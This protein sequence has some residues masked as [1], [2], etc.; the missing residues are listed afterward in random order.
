MTPTR[1]RL[2]ITA[3]LGLCLAGCQTSS[4]SGGMETVYADVHQG[5]LEQARIELERVLASQPEEASL[6]L[7]ERA[8]LHQRMR[9]FAASRDDFLRADEDFEVIDFSGEPGEDFAL[10]LARPKMAEYRGTPYEKILLNTLNIINHLALSDLEEGR[11]EARRAMVMHESVVDYERQCEF[12]NPLTEL[13]YGFLFE[14]SGRPDD[15]HF[16]Y[17]QAYEQ[18]G[19]AFLKPRLEWCARQTGHGDLLRWEQEFGVLADPVPEGCGTLVVLLMDGGAP[20][21]R[22]TVTPDRKVRY[23]ALVPRPHGCQGARASVAAGASEP[24]TLVLD[25]ERQALAYFERVEEKTLAGARLQDLQSPS[26]SHMYNI[27][28]TRSWNLLPAQVWA[29]VLSAPAGPQRVELELEGASHDT[30][31]LEVEVRAGGVQVVQFFAAE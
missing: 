6:L 7:L 19:A 18:T 9:D 12:Q 1:T 8:L 27:A 21:R 29:C 4:Y 28:D 10:L 3:L 20:V 22:P 13:L 11:V 30:L 17:K 24:L 25:I 16:A 26:G 15:A 14:A 23:A 31:A 2:R 5:R